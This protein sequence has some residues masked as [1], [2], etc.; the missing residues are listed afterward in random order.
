MRQSRINN[1]Y[2]SLNRDTLYNHIYNTRSSKLSSSSSKYIPSY[3]RNTKDTAF[4]ILSQSKDDKVRPSSRLNRKKGKYDHITSKIT[5]TT[6]TPKTP[7]VSRTN[8]SVL[9]SGLRR[10]PRLKEKYDSKYN[11]IN[12]YSLRHYND[13]DDDDDDDDYFTKYRSSR[14]LNKYNSINSNNI[15]SQ[16]KSISSANKSRSRKSNI[17][18]HKYY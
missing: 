1:N 9:T 11:S 6:S 17:S 4:S 15:S 7:K 10:S 2:A 3:H 8:S 12:K 5:T 13:D 16:Y 14:N 18:Y